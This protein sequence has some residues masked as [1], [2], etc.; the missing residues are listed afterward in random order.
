MQIGMHGIE[1]DFGP[2]DP[3]Q[4]NNQPKWLSRF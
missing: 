2:E 1:T 3:L 4:R